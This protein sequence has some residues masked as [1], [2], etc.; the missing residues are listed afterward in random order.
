[1]AELYLEMIEYLDR[2]LMSY[3][4]YMSSINEPIQ[5]DLA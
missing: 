1:M 3:D 4:D 2:L 5:T